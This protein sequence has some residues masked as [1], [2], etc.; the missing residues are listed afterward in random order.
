MKGEPSALERGWWW[1]LRRGGGAAAQFT[2]LPKQETQFVTAPRG[3]LAPVGI[4]GSNGPLTPRPTANMTGSR[5][6][7]TGHQFKLDKFIQSKET[8]EAP[9]LGEQRS[10]ME[11]TNPEE[12]T[13]MLKDIMEAIQGV[14]GTLESKIV[15]VS[16]E[17]ALKRADFYKL[18]ARVKKTEDSLKMLKENSSVLK[19]QVRKLKDTTTTLDAKVKDFERC[20]TETTSE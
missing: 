17:V 11:S 10:E 6:A 4:G 2:P 20:S 15:V 14:C 1:A 9:W 19:E 8:T 5:K 12:D 16:A 3:R 7:K 18:G 13:L